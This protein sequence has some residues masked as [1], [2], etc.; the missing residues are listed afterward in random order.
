MV[1]VGSSVSKFKAGSRVGV[2]CMVNSCRRCGPCESGMEQYCENGN[3][4]T[5]GSKDRDGAMTQG[6]YSTFNVVDEDFV[7][8][9]PDVIALAHAGPM[10]CAGI[11]VYSPLRR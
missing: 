11:T 9:I 6:G 2:G 4:L 10:L 8:G 5:Y 3:V 7:I 1:A